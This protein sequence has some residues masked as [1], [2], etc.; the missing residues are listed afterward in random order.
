MPYDEESNLKAEI[1]HVL[2]EHGA[3]VTARDDSHSTPLHLASSNWSPNIVRLLIEHDADVDVVDE[4]HKTPLLLASSG[5][6]VKPA[7][8]LQHKAY[9]NEQ[10]KQDDSH[11]FAW[12]DKSIARAETV[13]VLLEHGADVT[14]QDDAY[15]MPLHLAS[16]EGAPDIA[17]LLIEYGA[18]INSLDGNRKTPLH[19]AASGVSA[20]KKNCALVTAEG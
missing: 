18:D 2:L 1:V 4:N 7:L 14:A 11:S 16:S 20:Q 15:S 10:K 8:L 13:R 6:S 5:V 9:V 17:R 19:L 12:E 3:D